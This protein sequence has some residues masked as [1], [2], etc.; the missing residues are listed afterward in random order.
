[1]DDVGAPAMYVKVR[2]KWSKGIQR[3]GLS[4]PEQHAIV[5]KSKTQ[6]RIRKEERALFAERNTRGGHTS[7]D[8]GPSNKKKDHL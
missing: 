4:E 3:G 2:R 7:D 6:Q 5:S 8:W 1:V